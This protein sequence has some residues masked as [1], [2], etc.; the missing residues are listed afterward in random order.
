MSN[1]LVELGQRIER[2][3]GHT[4]DNFVPSSSSII[5][6]EE[7]GNSPSSTSKGSEH[8]N[9]EREE[10][11]AG[12]QDELRA[13]EDF[14]QPIIP[15]SPSCILLPTEARN[16]DLKS[17]HVHMFPSFYGL[18]N[19]DPLAHIKEFYNVVSAGGALK[20]K[21]AQ[22]SYNIYEMLGSNAQH[23]DLRGVTQ[24]DNEKPNE[25]PSHA[26]SSFE[27]PNLHKAQ[28]NEPLQTVLSQSQDE[29]DEEDALMEEVAA[30]EALAP[31]PL[32]VS[33]LLEPL[34]SSM[35][36]LTPSTVKH[37]NLNLN[38]FHHI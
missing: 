1:R 8:F 34:E 33:P 21:N 30:L 16:Y 13:L 3:K 17:S 36:H 23:K 27:A 35:S 25:E 20:K 32:N 15:N 37:Q 5:R 24:G 10:K 38:H 14:A 6:E 26:T 9:W 19:E 12:N 2:L 31:Y 22:E 28:S 18:P 7:E 11:M 4:L 29:F